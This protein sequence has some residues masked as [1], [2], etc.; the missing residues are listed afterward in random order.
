MSIKLKFEQGVE[1]NIKLGAGG[2]DVGL[3]PTIDRDDSFSLFGERGCRT[4]DGD[5]GSKATGEF[6][7]YK[8]VNLIT[9]KN[10]CKDLG[11][12]CSGYEY[13]SRGKCEV[14]K[15][16]I[17]RSKVKYMNGV[18]CYIK[19]EGRGVT[20][21]SDDHGNQ[22]NLDARDLFSLVDSNG[23][24]WTSTRKRWNE[25][26]INNDFKWKESHRDK[27]TVYLLGRKERE[28][29]TARLELD[30]AKVVYCP[31]NG[32]RCFKFATIETVKAERE[33]RECSGNKQVMIYN[34]FINGKFDGGRAEGEYQLT[35]GGNRYFP[36][37]PSDCDQSPAGYC[38]WDEREA[39]YIGNRASWEQVSSGGSITVG[40]REHDSVSE[41]LSELRDVSVSIDM[42]DWYINTCETY[43]VVVAVGFDAVEKSH[44][45]SLS[46]ALENEMDGDFDDCGYWTA[47]ED[48]FIW[49]IEVKPA[50][51]QLKRKRA[52]RVFSNP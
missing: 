15:A 36:D 16:P 11:S 10:K 9:C 7:L 40:T 5:K 42:N 39:H 31:P 35:L 20:S 37:G 50:P 8:N 22:F 18:D 52:F 34:F 29:A 12:V 33:D 28:G 47:P 49:Y 27:N 25:H 3:L 26:A 17:D 24:T 19:D 4:K 46:P 23:C 21:T 6:E 41:I 32:E 30:T 51:E 45:L 44:C 13:S 14:W 48:S 1:C 38:E 2:P 43:D